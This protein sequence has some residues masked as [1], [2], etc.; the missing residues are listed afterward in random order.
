M[1]RVRGR[2]GARQSDQLEFNVTCP[3]VILEAALLI[4]SSNLTSMGSEEPSTP[5]FL[6]QV[7][8]Q[9]PTSVGGNQSR[10]FITL[11]YAQS[12]DG[13]IAGQGGTQILLSGKESM[14]LTHWCVLMQPQAVSIQPSA[15][16]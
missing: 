13:C 4:F 14:V 6:K 5:D 3:H 8:P 11:T 2:G 9:G 15:S 1:W 12:L 16:G 7:Y 10:P